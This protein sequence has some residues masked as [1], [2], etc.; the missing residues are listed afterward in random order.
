[1]QSLRVRGLKSL[2]SPDQNHNNNNRT[3]RRKSRFFYNLFT[4]PRNVSNTHV[5]VA[6]AQSCANHVQHIERLS[7]ATCRVPRGTKGQL[8]LFVLQILNRIYFRLIIMT[9]PL[10][11]RRTITQTEVDLTCYGT[12]PQ[13]SN[14]KNTSANIDPLRPGAWKSSHLG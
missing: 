12:K 3:D 9:E 4:A 8:R 5:L 7:R 14:T 11:D 13:F 1:M 2:V 6:R 10:T